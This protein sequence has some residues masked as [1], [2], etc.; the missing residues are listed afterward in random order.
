MST[1]FNKASNLYIQHATPN[2]EPV[3]LSETTR[4]NVR[5][6][7]AI[8]GQAV[9]ITQKTTGVIHSLIDKMA[10]KIG[11]TASGS[12]TPI[13]G[14]KG[15]QDASTTIEQPQKP[16]LISRLL[17]STNMV[18]SAVEQSTTTIIQGGGKSVAAGI[19]HK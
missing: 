5:R 2:A 8:S 19:H 6:V 17:M 3:V 1:G 18:V 10:T 15:S 4:N 16:K 9:T 11:S 13:P 14:E 7:H 12:S